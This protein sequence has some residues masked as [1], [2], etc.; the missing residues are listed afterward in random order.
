MFKVGDIVFAKASGD[1]GVVVDILDEGAALEISFAAKKPE[2]LFELETVLASEVESF[3]ERLRR[4]LDQR[5]FE[6]QLNA[7]YQEEYDTWKQ[8][9][10]K[11]QAPV[12]TEA[13]VN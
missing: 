12:P 13:S 8:N 2:K 1:S 9:R 5:L 4:E 6:M 7:E 10:A 11:M 3:D